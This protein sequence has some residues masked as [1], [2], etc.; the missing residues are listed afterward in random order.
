MEQIKNY[1]LPKLTEDL[2]TNEAKSSIA[3]SKEITNKVNEL[4]GSTWKR[5]STK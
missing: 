1:L 5:G 3:L 2:F 4:V